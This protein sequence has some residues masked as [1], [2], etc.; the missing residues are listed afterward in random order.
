MFSTTDTIVAIATPPG[1]GGIG[2]VRAQ[3]PRRARDRAR[4]IAQREPLA[5]RHA[6]FTTVRA[7]PDATLSTSA[8]RCGVADRVDAIDQ[9]VATYFPAP[10]SY[11]GEDVVELSAHGSPVVLRAI[12]AR[13][14]RRRRAAGRAR[15]VHA[16][17]VS[18]TAASI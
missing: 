6:T 17:R 10:H 11:T 4:L 5:P 9:V 3:R 8:R 13:G 16:A 2:V 14:D 1:R 7:E 18:R 15:R 12:V